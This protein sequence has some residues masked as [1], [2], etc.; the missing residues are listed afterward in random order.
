[1]L[2]RR[3]LPNLGHF[4][5]IQWTTIITPPRIT[6]PRVHRCAV[7]HQLS[8]CHH[9]A[10]WVAARVSTPQLPLENWHKHACL[11]TSIGG[12]WATKV[13]HHPRNSR[14]PKWHSSQL[15]TGVGQVHAA[16]G[17]QAGHSV[18]QLSRS[19]PHHLL[20]TT[21]GAGGSH[22]RHRH[23]L[24]GGGHLGLL[25]GLARQDGITGSLGLGEVPVRGSGVL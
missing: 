23:Q 11:Q 24:W 1:M 18:A 2:C 5:A 12:P 21:G 19:I 13:A 14:K 16:I 17:R 22:D 6:T 25:E 15:H 10:Q 7:Q 4:S 3:Q 9:H 20:H 8:L